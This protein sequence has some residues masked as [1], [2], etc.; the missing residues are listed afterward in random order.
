MRH[1]TP[2][3]SAAS[4]PASASGV[5]PDVRTASAPAG[6]DRARAVGMPAGREEMASPVPGITGPGGTPAGGGTASST[7]AVAKYAPTKPEAP[8]RIGRRLSELRFLSPCLFGFAFVRAFYDIIAGQLAT[9]MPGPGGAGWLGQDLVVLGMV[10]AFIACVVA[11]R[12]LLPLS[13]KR[14]AAPLALTLMLAGAALVLAASLLAGAGPSGTAGSAELVG[15][16]TS[17]STNLASTGATGAADDTGPA[18]APGGADPTDTI[19]ADA[20]PDGPADVAR[21]TAVATGTLD[22][23]GFVAPLALVGGL[24][25]GL[26]IALGILLWAELQSCFGSFLIVL[27]VAGGFFLGSLLGWLI[28]GLGGIRLALALLALP[29]LSHI[30]LRWGLA[31]VP[32]VDRPGGAA[33]SLQFPWRLVVAL[34]VYEFALGVR[35]ASGPF[36][37]EAFTAGVLASSAI[38]FA[39]VYFFSHRFDFTYL[40]RTPFVLMS[41]GLLVTFAS[42]SSGSVAA[43]VLVCVGYAL[44]FLVLTVLLCDIAHRYGVSAALLCSI[45]E[46]VM[47]TSLGGHGVGFALER[48]SSAPGADSPVVLV[49]LVIL[50]IV[51]SMVLLTEREYARWGVTLFGMEGLARDAGQGETDA[52]GPACEALAARI[53]LSPREKEVLQLLAR[54]KGPGDI[55]RELCIASGT[56]KSHTRRIYRKADVHSREE[57]IALLAPPENPA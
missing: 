54:G 43:D 31:G 22:P 8:E 4:A 9:L 14:V 46:L 55:E 30:C 42:L 37:G 53:G 20:R 49:G 35:Q 26:G 52:L 25:A 2:A 40:Y 17:S 12:R 44:M 19:A 13:G 7:G 39:L 23:A 21:G 51:A 3:Q 33:R 28:G 47:L 48:G 15:A 10:P 56:L 1:D 18:G 57:L 6:R 34:G 32:S 11:S 45:Q 36:A 27:Y 41:C 38:L 5:A 24:L 50:V 29:P 16:G